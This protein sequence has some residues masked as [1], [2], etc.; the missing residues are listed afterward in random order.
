MNVRLYLSYDIKNSL[1]S[2]FWRKKFIILSLCTQRR[3][4]RHNVSRQSVNQKVVYRFYCMA[5]F[6]SWTQ[7]HMLNM[8]HLDIKC[9]N[10]LFLAILKPLLCLI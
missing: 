4:G 6:H 7:H 5:L 2:H 8:Y 1:N 10:L 3:Y 9:R